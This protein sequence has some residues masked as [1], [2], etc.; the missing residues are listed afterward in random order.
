MI[1]KIATKNYYKYTFKMQYVI[2]FLKL[3]GAMK[4]I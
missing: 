4:S 1:N 3:D 2:Y